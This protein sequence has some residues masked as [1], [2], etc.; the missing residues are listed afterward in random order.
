MITS[1]TAQQGK[2][3]GGRLGNPATPKELVGFM[4]YIYF[5]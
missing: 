3:S 2:G 4:S 5:I 1:N